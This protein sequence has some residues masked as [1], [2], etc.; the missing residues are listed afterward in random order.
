MSKDRKTVLLI[1]GTDSSS[2]ILIYEKDVI[3]DGSFQELL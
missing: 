3:K 2:F 1:Y